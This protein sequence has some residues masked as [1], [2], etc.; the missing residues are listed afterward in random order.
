MSD[1]GLPAT[2]HPAVPR[3]GDGDPVVARVHVLVMTDDQVH[4]LQELLAGADI[5]LDVGAAAALPAVLHTALP[6]RLPRESGSKQVRVGPVSIDMARHEVRVDGRPVQLTP[7]EFHLL[8]RMASRPG[9]VLTRRQLLEQLHGS[10]EFLTE[11]T[12]DSHVLNLRRKI[13]KD[14][15]RPM[16]IR[17]VYGMGYKLVVDAATDHS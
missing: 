10:A 2:A 3:G 6:L 4:R 11:R 5:T 7:T 14:A 8:V 13:E 17:T 15:T 1:F 16:L 12:V 9:Q